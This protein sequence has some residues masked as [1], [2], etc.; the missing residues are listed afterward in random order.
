MAILESTVS[1]YHRSALLFKNGVP[2]SE[3]IFFDMYFLNGERVE[4]MS[5]YYLSVQKV[6]RV[7]IIVPWKIESKPKVVASTLL[8]K[9]QSQQ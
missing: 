1:K 4:G 8:C 6:E 7:V 5:K 3:K 9:E 2:R